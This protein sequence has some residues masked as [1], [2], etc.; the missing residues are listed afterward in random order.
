MLVFKTSSKGLQDMSSR[1]LQDVCSVK[2]FRLPRRIARC[3]QDMFARRLQ[4]VLEDKNLLR[5]RR[6]EDVLKTN[7]CLLGR[8]ENVYFG[9]VLTILARNLSKI[10]KFSLIFCKFN[11]LIVFVKE[12]DYDEKFFFFF[13]YSPLLLWCNF[14]LLP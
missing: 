9:V 3:L 8:D 11:V 6:V 10:F 2:I 1:R 12:I 13:S 4:D 14:F 7:K 5:W